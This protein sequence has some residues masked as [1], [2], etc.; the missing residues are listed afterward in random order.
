[1]STATEASAN[2][3][4]AAAIRRYLPAMLI[5]A[6]GIALWELVVRVFGIQGF[7]LPRPSRIAV[8]FV[9][10]FPV[11]AAAGWFT[12]KKALLGFALGASSGIGI[13]MLTARLPLVREGVMPFAIAVNSTPIIALAPIMNNWFPITSLWPGA[14]VVAL[15]VFFPVMIN[16]VRGLSEVRHGFVELMDSYGAPPRAV[17]FKMR[18]PNALP[19]LFSAFKVGTTLSVIAAVV[20]EYFGG[21]R[22]ALGVY[23]S[24]QAALFH[25]AEAWSA[26]IIASAFGILFYLLIILV[27]RIAIPWH[28]SVRAVA[29]G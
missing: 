13:A 7:L 2:A 25:F 22:E 3:R 1:M 19:Y 29:E 11:V 28:A 23:I 15:V 4:A 16:M 12:A 27:E 17:L 20:S 6:T 26:I 5:F 9:D 14:M 8:V 24:Q 21:S 18:I 10:E